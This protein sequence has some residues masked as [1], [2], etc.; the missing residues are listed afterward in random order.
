LYPG[1]R[2]Q[3]TY[4]GRNGYYFAG[5]VDEGVCD[6]EITPGQTVVDYHRANEQVNDVTV[7]RIEAANRRAVKAYSMGGRGTYT[8]PQELLALQGNT[9]NLTQFAPQFADAAR[10][11]WHRS[12]EERVKSAHQFARSIDRFRVDGQT[13]NLDTDEEVFTG[14][15]RFEFTELYEPDD[16]ILTFADGRQGPHPRNTTDLRAHSPPDSFRVAFIYPENFEGDRADRIWRQVA[17]TADDLGAKPNRV[18][19]IPYEPKKGS[20][21]TSQTASHVAAEVGQEV[22]ID[23]ALCVLPPKEDDLLNF[24]IPYDDLKEVLGDQSI[25]SQMVH[26][27]TVKQPYTHTNLALGLIAAAGGIP[28]TIED[29]LPGD[30]DLVIGLD[31]GQSFDD[32]GS[33]ATEGIRVGASTTAIYRDG[34][35]LGHTNTGAQTGERIPARKMMKIVR[36]V[37]IGYRQRFDEAPEHIV[38]HRD[39]FMNDPLDEVKAYLSEEDITYDIVEVRKQSPARVVNVTDYGYT[40]PSKGIASIDRALNRAFL[41]TFGDPEDLAGRGTPRPITV[42]RAEGPTDIETLTRQV[43]LLAQCHIGVSNTTVRVPISTSYADRAA[44]AAADGHLA[45]TSELET[46]IGFI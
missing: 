44:T 23:A 25:D 32:S 6:H 5:F 12:P 42:E 16:D 38:I 18:F 34:T 27:D 26:S 10:Q 8:F 2:I 22:D 15:E 17:G 19:D 21:G 14:D 1:R 29:T 28:F 36:Q 35:I 45:K 7:D 33:S 3:T 46:G 13:V 9:E 39:G 31:V 40:T 41:L 11:E 24:A 30:A 20:A 37:V 4:D 43:Y